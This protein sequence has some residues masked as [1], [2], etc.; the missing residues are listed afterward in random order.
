MF[1]KASEFKKLVKDSWERGTLVLGQR[2]GSLLIEGTSWAIEYQI[3]TIPNKIKAILVEMCGE[4][5][6]EEQ[7][8]RATKG[9]TN[10][11]SFEQTIVWDWFYETMDT[12][13]NLVSITRAAWIGK[14]G[15][16]YRVAKSG[17]ETMLVPH[18]YLNT[19][20][21]S[22]VEEWEDTMRGPYRFRNQGIYWQNSYGTAIFLKAGLAKDDVAG[23][24]YIEAVKA[25]EVRDE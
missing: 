1:I 6:S 20:D 13:K 25:A 7:A 21:N 9:S 14:S 4:I 10:Q 22:A 3:D 16:L 8:F 12:E 5:P 23:E 11:Y 2:D 15:R 19:V 17:K 24:A 18:E